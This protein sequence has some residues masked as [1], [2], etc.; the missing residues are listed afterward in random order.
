MP[1]PAT[2]PITI[3][4]DLLPADGRFGSGPSKVRA[5]QVRALSDA[6]TS[7]LGTSHRQAPVRSVVRRVRE[8]LAEL[9][10]LPEGYEVVLGNGGS[11]TFWDVATACL[12]RTKAQ[13]A[14]FGEFGAKF[15]AATTAAPFLEASQVIAAPPG[16]VALP[17]PADD[18]DVHAWPHNETSTGAMAPVVRVPGSR[19]RGALTLVDATSGAGALPVD[20]AETD[21]YYFAPQKVFG[22]DGGLWLALCSPDALARAEE[23]ESS[24]TRWVP[25]SLS[26][27]AA[28]ANSRQDQTLNTPAIATLVMLA[29]QVEWILGHGGLAWAAARS[30]ESAAHLYGWAEEREWA[31]PFVADPAERST[32][33]GTIDLDETIDATAV[34]STLRAHG[35]LDVF[36][37]RKLGRNQLR[38]AM[39]P[40][41]D[42]DDVRALTA[43]VDHVVSRLA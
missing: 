18:V 42:P 4:A 38:V 37:Y 8:G 31:T 1:D 7:L 39:F 20:V 14:A 9:F 33:V 16:T 10:S 17:A 15:A 29:E 23:V 34:V 6:G 5:E 2:A 11:T 24:G 21:V 12:V 30:A 35:V 22:S 36:P 40:A 27:R 3:P 13:H 43:C 25:E 28:A 41:I 32:V 26:L 19:E